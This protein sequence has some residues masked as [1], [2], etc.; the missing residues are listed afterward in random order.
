MATTTRKAIITVRA[1]I[2]APVEKVWNFWSDPKHIIHWNNASD[3]WYTPR[4]END[5]RIGGKFNSRMEARDGSMGFDFT[6]KYTKVVYHKQ[7]EYLLD[8]DRKV[9][10]NFVSEG[11]ETIVT[12]KFEAEQ[13]NSLE[14]QQTG[15]QAILNNFKKYVESSG[16]PTPLQFE[17]LIDANIDKVY[18]TMIGEKTY[19]EWTSE[20][21]PTSHFKGSWEKGS[22]IQFIGTD[23]NGKQGGMVS[24]IKENIPHKFIS[25][26]HLA[27]IQDGIEIT[28]GPEIEPWKGGFENYTFCEENG[29]TKLTIEMGA[30]Q[31]IPK[32]FIAYFNATWP[33][34]LSKLK[35]ICEK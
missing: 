2:N 25:I 21:N 16:K 19:S 7:I 4:A 18:T 5:L 14:L 17:I 11:K 24:Q 31:E 28:S 3:D 23:Q 1:T 34:A 20:F 33:K 6:G 27:V 30:K 15:W 26:E 32:E 9:L 12:E 10:I 8:D 29:K 13:I 22:K 35:S